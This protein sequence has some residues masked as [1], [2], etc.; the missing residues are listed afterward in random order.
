MGHDSWM[1]S[2]ALDRVDV[3]AC[4]PHV[5]TFLIQSRNCVVIHSTVHEDFLSHKALLEH[6]PNDFFSITLPPI[7]WRRSTSIDLLPELLISGV[8]DASVLQR[9]REPL[10]NGND[11]RLGSKESG[12]RQ[13]LDEDRQG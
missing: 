3:E 10:R 2:A 7:E 13:D 8:H 12:V 1:F 5:D 6:G 9:L 4:V 11:R